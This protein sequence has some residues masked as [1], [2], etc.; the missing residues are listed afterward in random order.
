MS[1]AYQP[2]P[3]RDYQS[4]KETRYY[5]KQG[6]YTGKSYQYNKTTRYYDK[7]G[8]YIGSGRISK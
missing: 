8:K 4:P 5:D 2:Y 1:C 6:K 3:K 7:N